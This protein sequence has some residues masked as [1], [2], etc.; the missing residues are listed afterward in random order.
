M[1]GRSNGCEA[2]LNTFEEFDSHLHAGGLF[3][4]VFTYHCNRLVQQFAGPTCFPVAFS[5]ARTTKPKLPSLR[6]LSVEYLG[7]PLK[8]SFTSMVLG[9]TGPAPQVIGSAFSGP[10]FRL[11]LSQHPLIFWSTRYT[12]Q[13]TYYAIM[14]HGRFIFGCNCMG[15]QEAS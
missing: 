10:T 15:A 12:A 4:M 6:Y 9:M 8:G 1:D 14:E 2:H 5:L 3:W 13:L 11:M 7:W